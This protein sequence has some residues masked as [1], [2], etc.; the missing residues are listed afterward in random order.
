MKLLLFV[1]ASLSLVGCS[2]FGQSN[3]ETAP[4]T[5]LKADPEQNIEVRIYDE[6]ILVSAE[7]SGEGRNSAFRKLFRYISGENEGANEISMTAPV[8]MG[9]A[10]QAE[11]N[12]KGTEIA[13][14]AP[15]FMETKAGTPKMSFVMPAE[16]TLQT[17]PRPTN[18]DVTVSELKNYKVAAITFSGT[19]SRRNV[20]KHTEV[21]TNWISTNGYAAIGQPVEAGYNGPMT[22]PMLR[23][24]EV[25]IEIK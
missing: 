12:N 13:M 8:F 7:M 20:A 6:M 11:S 10:E 9:Q 2:V 25:L 4:Y 1:I 23:R 18:P 14:T 16:F 3:V 19:L 17:T 22:L 5:L 21:L 24:N 15:V